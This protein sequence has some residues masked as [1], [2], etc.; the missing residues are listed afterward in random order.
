MPPCRQTGSGG[1]PLSTMPWLLEEVSARLLQLGLLSRTT[2]RDSDPTASGR[3]LTCPTLVGWS[4][5]DDME[6]LYG[7]PLEV[8]RPWASD[9]SGRP[10]RQRP[11]HGHPA[12]NDKP[13]D[14]DVC[15]TETVG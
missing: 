9:L 12:E 15:F 14:H 10:S 1:Y 13:A 7:D 11:S 6:Q 4:T 2:A 3:M 8:W 5:Q